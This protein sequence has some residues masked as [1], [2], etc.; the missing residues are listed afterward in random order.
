MPSTLCEGFIPGFA[1]ADVCYEQL[2]TFGQLSLSFLA[3][4]VSVYLDE[5]LRSLNVQSPQIGI[6]IL[7]ISYVQ[8][9]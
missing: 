4:P 1:V 3:M 9:Q 8:K 5:Y 6:D 2:K 7:V